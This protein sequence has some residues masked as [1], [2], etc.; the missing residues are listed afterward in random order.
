MIRDF[1]N[2]P[3]GDDASVHRGSRRRSASRR[4]GPRVR[5]RYVRIPSARSTANN[6]EQFDLKPVTFVNLVNES[7]E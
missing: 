1:A 3:R 6:M 5:V 7:S 2:P 4:D